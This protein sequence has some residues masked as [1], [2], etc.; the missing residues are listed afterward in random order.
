MGPEV[1]RGKQAPRRCP[2]CWSAGHTL[3]SKVSEV[4][5]VHSRQGIEEPLEDSFSFWGLPPARQ[6]WGEWREWTFSFMSWRNG[7]RVSLGPAF[8]G[9]LGKSQ[10]AALGFLLGSPAWPLLLSA[11]PAPS[12]LLPE[13][14]QLLLWP[15]HPLFPHSSLLPSPSCQIFSP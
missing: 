15:S 12:Q 5:R 2:R 9:A 3:C 11:Q 8:P 6:G 13:L 4:I 10:A 7:P 14:P 1:V